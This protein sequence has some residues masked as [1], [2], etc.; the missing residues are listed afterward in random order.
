MN[1]IKQTIIILSTIF[2]LNGCLY[3]D[4]YNLR[5]HVFDKEATNFSDLTSRLLM[6]L[7]IKIKS[8]HSLYSHRNFYLIDFVNIDRLENYSQLGFILNDEVKTHVTQIYDWPIK[9]LK[10]TKN[11]K[12]GPKGTKF[13]S[14]DILE[15]QN[16]TINKNG[17]ALVGTYSI[18][19]RQLIIYLKLIN[20]NTGFILKSATVSTN[21]TDEII[22]LDSVIY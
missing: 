3:D 4:P 9:E 2:L 17:Y 11:L 13:L 14:R 19:Q 5:P 16:Q 7:D 21:L 10:M 12:M 1:K 18:T 8:V 20:I 15:I 22:L 6:Q